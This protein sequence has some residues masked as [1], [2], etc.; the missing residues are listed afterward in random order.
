MQ[1]RKINHRNREMT[2]MIELI[3]KD[4]IQVMYGIIN[5]FHVFKKVEESMNIRK[6][7]EVIED[8]N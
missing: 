6:D 4:L 8:S 2:Q 5:T 1:R 3:F 7:T